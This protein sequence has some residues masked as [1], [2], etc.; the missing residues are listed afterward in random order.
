MLPGV[1]GS[2]AVQAEPCI[3]FFVPADVLSKPG[4]HFIFYIQEITGAEDF[5]RGQ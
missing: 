5:I 3:E 2:S 4:R 1:V